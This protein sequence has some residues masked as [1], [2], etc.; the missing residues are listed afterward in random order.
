MP[1]YPIIS[2]FPY[3]VLKLLTLLSVK[4]FEKNVLTLGLIK[5]FE[6]YSSLAKKSTLFDR[7]KIRQ[8]S[9]ESVNQYFSNIFINCAT[10][11]NRAKIKK[12]LRIAFF[13]NKNNI[14]YVLRFQHK[15]NREEILH[16][17]NNFMLDTVPEILKKKCRKPSRFGSFVKVHIFYNIFYFRF[18]YRFNYIGILD[19][20]YSWLNNLTLQILHQGITSPSLLEM[21]NKDTNDLVSFVKLNSLHIIN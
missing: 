12:K 15:T 16:N 10:E 13:K 11:A 2:F 1:I 8:N 3:L 19:I 4:F 20:R 7:Y 5:Y 21:V 18:C 17:M 9:L 6:K 14:G